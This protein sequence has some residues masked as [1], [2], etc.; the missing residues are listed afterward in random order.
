M[1]RLFSGVPLEELSKKREVG[2]QLHLFC[3]VEFLELNMFD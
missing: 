2:R 3:G 1:T